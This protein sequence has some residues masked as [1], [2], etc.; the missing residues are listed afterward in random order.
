V[1]AIVR[2]GLRMLLMLRMKARPWRAG[3]S[4]TNLVSGR[5]SGRYM[6]KTSALRGTEANTCPLRVVV[7]IVF[8]L[9]NHQIGIAHR[10]APR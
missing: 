5:F 9:P 3:E 8:A 4:P 1:A 2:D 10:C 6:S 7:A